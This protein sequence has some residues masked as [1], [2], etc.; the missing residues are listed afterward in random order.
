MKNSLYSKLLFHMASDIKY[1]LNELKLI[2][3]DFKVK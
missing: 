3:D 1:L 2:A